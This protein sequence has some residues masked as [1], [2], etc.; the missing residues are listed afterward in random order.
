MAMGSLLRQARLD[1]GLS[2]RQLCGEEITRNML[3]QIE[4]GTAKPS[5][6]TLR[7]LASRLEKPVS[8]FLEESV[9]PEETALAEARKA[10]EAGD[11]ESAQKALENAGKTPESTLLSCLCTL[12]QARKAIAESKKPYAA[13]LLTGLQCKQGLYLPQELEKQR[14][15]LLY[16][17]DPRLAEEIE[18]KLPPE[19]AS[20]LV[21]AA[22]A[23]KQA[24][25][26][27]SIHLLESAQHRDS[28]QWLLLRGQASLALERYSEAVAYFLQV[29][30]AALEQLEQCYMHL[31]D[32]EKAYRYAVLRRK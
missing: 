19:D 6:D 10:Y 26:Q 16:Q 24:Q 23:Q 1:A 18:K 30:D 32:Y 5:M 7:Y 27:Q 20:L 2:Q 17:A 21:W 3:S 31:G 9:S 4:N 22:S 28:R 11:W 15:L 12:A 25:W 14:L 29:E 8:F 13:K